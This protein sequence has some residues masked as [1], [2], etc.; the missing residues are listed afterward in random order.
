VTRDRRHRR[1]DDHYAVEE[2]VSAE[3]AC[4]NLHNALPRKRHA[5]GG[6][7]LPCYTIGQSSWTHWPSARRRTSWPA[8]MTTPHS[9]QT[10]PGACASLSSTSEPA[11]SSCSGACSGRAPPR[12]SKQALLDLAAS[13]IRRGCHVCLLQPGRCNQADPSVPPHRLPRRDPGVA[14]G[15]PRRPEANEMPAGGN[16]HSPDVS[17]H[18]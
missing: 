16:G 10:M 3:T 2:H 8:V 6:R 4:E 7:G 14:V 17:G 12:S 5:G 9:P 18:S 1:D 13:E 15:R 11:S